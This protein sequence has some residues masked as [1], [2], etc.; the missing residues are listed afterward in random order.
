ML[1]NTVYHFLQNNF[2]NESEKYINYQTKFTGFEELDKNLGGIFPALYLLGAES[3]LGKTTFLHQIADYLAAKGN[4][5]LYFSL[6]QSKMELV[7][8]SL[9]RIAL[10]KL[11]EKVTSR[12]IMYNT[13]TEITAQAIESYLDYSKNMMIFEGNFNTTVDEIKKD[14][15]KAIEFTGNLE[16]IVF[17]DYLQVIQSK[18]SRMNDKQKTD[19]NIT[20]LKR[21]SRDL[22]I[23]IFVISSLNRDGYLKP[24]GYES[25]K[26]SGSIEFTADIL[27]GLQ[28]EAVNLIQDLKSTSEKQQRMDIAKNEN[29]RKIELVCKKN[30]GGQQNFKL[31]FKYYPQYNFFVENES[32]F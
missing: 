25:F 22:F 32:L 19:I 23:P 10:T 2:Y 24:I 11:D 5:V 8:K 4:S 9:S 13:D 21:I 1:E 27:I 18:D 14:I 6:E 29:P 17:I 26:E 16:P 30:R 28:Y 20:E 7:S 31:P 3:S 15:I 12:Q